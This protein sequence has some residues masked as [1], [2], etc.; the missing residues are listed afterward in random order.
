MDVRF[1]AMDRLIGR[2]CNGIMTI[3]TLTRTPAAPVVPDLHPML[4]AEDLLWLLLDDVTGK[5]LVDDITLASVLAGAVLVELTPDSSMRI[6]DGGHPDPLMSG[7]LDLLRRRPITPK[8]AV[9]KL[10]RGLRGALLER[11]Q[12]NRQVRRQSTR[13]LGLIPTVSWPTSD[14]AGQRELRRALLDGERADARSLQL[15]VLLNTVHALADQFPEWHRSAV[16]SRAQ[17]I[18]RQLPQAD[19]AT[20]AIRHAI[21]GAYAA[22]YATGVGGRMS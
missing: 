2:A 8:N 3:A 7:A 11:L 12:D 22:R 20:A 21:Q 9:D 17:Q 4:I 10:A 1:W 6:P 16:E 13:R 14:V 18:T 15:V 5:P 19:W